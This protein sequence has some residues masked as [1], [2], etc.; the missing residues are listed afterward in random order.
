MA[1]ELE[2]SYWWFLDAVTGQRLRTAYAMDRPTATALYGN[3]RLD[4]PTR[5]VRV[6]CEFGEPVASAQPPSNDSPSPQLAP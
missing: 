3:V 5:V 6:V 4:E 2:L 1:N